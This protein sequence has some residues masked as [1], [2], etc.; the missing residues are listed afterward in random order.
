MTDTEQLSLIDGESEEALLLPAEEA[1][2]RYTGSTAEKL[3]VRRNLI[4]LALGAG[5]AVEYIAREAHCSTRTVK[6]L[7]AKYA[8]QAARSTGEMCKV[9][10]SL[11]MKAA[12]HLDQKL[13]DAKPGELGVIMGIALQRKLEME[14]YGS[15][16]GDP[17]EVVDV[18]SV[19]PALQSAREFVKQLEQPKPQMNTDETQIQNGKAV[20]V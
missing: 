19:N 20:E 1:R 9:L 12:F 16:Q 7:G 3:E 5:F 18:E 8:T 15:G 10:G 14:A 17:G 4:L 6:I 13:T 2:K 11:A